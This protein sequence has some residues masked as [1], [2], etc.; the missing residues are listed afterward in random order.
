MPSDVIRLSLRLDPLA[1]LVV[2]Q[3]TGRRPRQPSSPRLARSRQSADNAVLGR[4]MLAQGHG[5]K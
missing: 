2:E 4:E 1:W 5:L 3:V